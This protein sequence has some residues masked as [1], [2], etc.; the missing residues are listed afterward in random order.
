MAGSGELTAQRRSV[1]GRAAG[2][3]CEVGQRV[4]RI[5]R[6]VGHE[7]G[8]CIAGAAG[9]GLGDDLVIDRRAG[10]DRAEGAGERAAGTGAGKDLDVQQRMVDIAAV[11]GDGGGDAFEARGV[12]DGGR[13]R[14]GRGGVRPPSLTA[15]VGVAWVMVTVA[16]LLLAAPK[17][18]LPAKLAT[19][20]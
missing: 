10:Q 16:G 19:A 12:V 13:R 2:I 18:L 14:V 17:S 6:A 4:E 20:V 7:I 11:V 8:V 9:G 5:G 15:T 1:E 3:E